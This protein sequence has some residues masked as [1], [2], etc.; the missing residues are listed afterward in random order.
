MSLLLAALLVFAPMGA[1]QEVV[2]LAIAEADNSGAASTRTDAHRLVHLLRYGAA[3]FGI[4]TTFL[5][6]GASAPSLA[7]GDFNHDGRPDLAVA[8]AE[9]DAVWL[10]RG[11]GTGG[12]GPPTRLA[13]D[14][15]QR[16]V[17]RGDFDGDGLPDQAMADQFAS[18]V[19][20]LFGAGTGD[21]ST[22]TAAADR[23]RV[24]AVVLGDFSTRTGRSIWPWWTAWSTT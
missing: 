9:T 4:P 23:S 7:I 19:T 24:P 20:L 14:A 1:G 17:A 15:R 18:G 2:T 10:L 22:T 13:I 5:L 21:F 12:F 16:L 11:D 8:E 6:G 3:S